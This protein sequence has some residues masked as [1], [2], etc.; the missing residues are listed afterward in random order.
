MMI[1][2]GFSVRF[3]ASSMLRSFSAYSI[4]DTGEGFER[5]I[6]LRHGETRISPWHDL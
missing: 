6:Y 4:E 3:H 2:R 5:R 1:S